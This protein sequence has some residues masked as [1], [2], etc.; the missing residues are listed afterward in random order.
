M[1]SEIGI[2]EKEIE[3]FRGAI[4]RE[5]EENMDLARKLYRA[6]EVPLMVFLDSQTGYYSL[7]ERFY[8]SITEW[9]ILVADLYRILGV[10]S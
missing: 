2:L 6:G 8:Q 5:G 4:L 10:D 9:K 7:Q 3:T 1:V